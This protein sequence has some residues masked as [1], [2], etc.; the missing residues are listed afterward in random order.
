MFLCFCVSVCLCF[1]ICSLVFMFLCFCL[2][3]F[4]FS[5]LSFWGFCVFVVLFLCVCF[6]CVFILMFFVFLCV[7][8][9]CF[10]LTVFCVLVLMFFCVF[11][12]FCVSV[13]IVCGSSFNDQNY[14]TKC[15]RNYLLQQ[16]NYVFI[17]YVH[18]LAYLMK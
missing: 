9:L 8:F 17:I 14:Q 18:T 12:F 7:C 16:L 11:V 2:S 6:C 13:F 10:C 5:F 4:D 3:V 15:F 1:I